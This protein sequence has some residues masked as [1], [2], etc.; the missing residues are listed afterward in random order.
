MEGAIIAWYAV[1]SFA[2]YIRQKYVKMLDNSVA[3][4]LC[5]WQWQTL[6]TFLTIYI[7]YMFVKM[8]VY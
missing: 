2:A 8:L 7:S 3:M 4:F 5:K 1:C 6:I